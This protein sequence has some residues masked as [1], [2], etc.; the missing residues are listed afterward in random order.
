L[1]K[2]K[3][4]TAAKPGV[5]ATQPAIAPGSTAL[6]RT[7]AE[8]IV[9]DAIRHYVAERRAMIP[10]FVKKNYSLLGSL[11]LH[12]H[13]FG[14]DM[15]RAPVNVLAS[16]ATVGQRGLA[17]GLKGLGAKRAAKAIRARNL[18]LRT[19]VGREIDWRIRTELLELPYKHKDRSFER[20]AILETVLK[21]PRVEARLVEVL[22]A[23]GARRDDQEFEAK[24]TAAMTEYVGSRAAAADMTASLFA[25]AT[26]FVAYHQFTPGTAALSGVIA[27]KIAYTA[28]INSYWAGSWLG[29]FMYSWVYSASATPLLY[30]S[31]FTG[32]MI[33]LAILTAFAG[34]VADPVQNALGLHKRRLNKM[35]DTLEKNLLG[36]GEA[37]YT[38]RDHYAARVMDFIDWTFAAIRLANMR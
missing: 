3:P 30:A 10:A 17:L 11:K 6:T 26:G 2:T 14:L 4:I 31:V 29:G 8:A 18:F 37:R 28:A 36:D 21:D 9:E 23:V 12:R 27:N 20:D 34:V 19:K 13:A 33:P 25:A 15:V 22:R 24:L 7:D 16:V 35:L 32:L 38:V 5:S 1:S